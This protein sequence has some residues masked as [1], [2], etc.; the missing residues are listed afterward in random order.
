MFVAGIWV[1]QSGLLVLVGRGAASSTPSEV[2]A[3]F[4]PFWEVWQFAQ[5]QYFDQPL[6]NTA[7]VEGAISGMLETLGD[8]N[9]IYLPPQEQ[10]FA[11]EESQGEIQ[12]I[13]AEVSS[14]DGFVVIVS[15]ID[16]SPAE[17]AGLR[18]GDI[19]LSADNID[20]FDMDIGEAAAIVRGPAGSTVTLTIERDGET[21]EVDIVRA[22][23]E[24]ASVRGEILDSGIAYVRL[25]RFGERT[26]EEL[27]EKLVELLAENPVGLIVDVRNNPGGALTT[28]VDIA[29]EFLDSGVI[30][31]ER[32]GNGEEDIFR[33][34]ED[35]IAQ[36][37]PLV[38]LINEGSAS[39]SEVLAGAIEDSGR[40]VLIG[41]QSFGKGTVQAWIPLS[42]SG[43]LR[44]TVA[45]WLTPAGTWVHESG[46]TPAYIIPSQESR[47]DPDLQL[48]GAVDFLLGREVENTVPPEATSAGN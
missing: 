44:L 21:F 6:D 46:L 4:Q 23:V 16:G 42:N 9:T 43:G 17:A 5:Q 39:A 2:R 28:V 36:D 7:L 48:D 15:P 32:Y 26:A 31:T 34:S 8:R 24:I 19:I 29:D 1:G 27:N 22:R 35:G 41:A 45:R 25:S 33:A 11:Q 38:V 13:G 18:P 14:E 10:Q 47:T 37:I 3:E 30:L 12:G 20:L 40:G